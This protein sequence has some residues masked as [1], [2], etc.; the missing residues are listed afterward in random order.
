MSTVPARFADLGDLH[1]GIDKSVFAID[2]L[3]GWA[4][5]DERAG[6]VDEGVPDEEE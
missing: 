6:A 1:A 5:R 3:I 2:E 4:E